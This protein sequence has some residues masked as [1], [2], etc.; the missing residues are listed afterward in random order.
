MQEADRI[1]ALGGSFHPP[2][3]AHA[4]LMRA[5]LDGLGAS[6]G[7]FV[8]SCGAYV[9]RKM[10]RS[11]HPDEVYP[12][13]LRLAMLQAMCADDPRMQVCRA[14]MADAKRSGHTYETL[15]AIAAEH[16]GAR[17]YFIFGADKLKA[18][19]RWPTFD[20]LTRDFRLI[21][22]TREG[23]DPQKAFAKIPKLAARR[24]AFVFLP[25]P[26]GAQD[27]SSTAVR[28]LMRSGGDPAPLMHPVAAALL[29]D[30]LRSADPR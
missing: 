16:P 14:E 22:F 17:V 23:F 8:P 28:D 7:Y 10:R 24:D 1:V 3:I 11:A 19:P 6:A 20:A 21:V 12:D 5:A 2:T 29:H 13:E 26:E 18:L 25:Q 4:R 15:S 9:R 30:A 27:V